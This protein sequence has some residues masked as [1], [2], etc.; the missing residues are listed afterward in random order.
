MRNRAIR[1]LP[2]RIA[3][4]AVMLVMFSLTGCGGGGGSN[5]GGGN[6]GGGNNGGTTNTTTVTITG[7]VRQNIDHSTPVQNATITILG[8][9][10]PTTATALTDSNG[11]FSVSGVPLTA[12]GFKVTAPTGTGYYNQ[13][14]YNNANYDFT[15]AH[16]PA[17]PALTTAGRA[18]PLPDFIEIYGSLDPNNG[19]P[20][21]P[22]IVN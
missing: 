12:T 15:A 7:T 8:P 2:A 10:V 1:S 6:N 13:I 16:T 11:R 17:L 5:N 3:L 21:P 14:H 18:Y 9:N 4:A 19:G 22:P 20:P